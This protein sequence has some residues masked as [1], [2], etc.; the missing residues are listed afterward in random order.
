MVRA[1]LAPGSALQASDRLVLLSLLQHAD[2]E[3]GGAR[4]SITRLAGCTGLG[5]HTVIASVRRLEALGYFRRTLKPGVRAVYAVDL[6]RCLDRTSPNRVPVSE[7]ATAGAIQAPVPVQSRHATVPLPLTVPE[8]N[9]LM[10]LPKGNAEVFEAWWT[11]YRTRTGRG[12]EK[13]AT[14]AAFDRLPPGDQVALLERTHAW[15]SA[16]EKLR[17]ASAFVPE[18]PD[19]KRFVAKRRWEDELSLPAE[20]AAASGR[21]PIQVR[22]PSPEDLKAI[23]R[24]QERAGPA[25]G[26]P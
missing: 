22:T 3:G 10:Q 12:A 16:R 7:S 20:A 5:R 13:T 19:P 15:F 8:R 1:V 24:A 23:E 26:A 11:L 9:H 6:N 14:R 2:S 4:P 18:A 25:G 17:L 21:P